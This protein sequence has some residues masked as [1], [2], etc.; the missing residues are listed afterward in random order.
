MAAAVVCNVG[1]KRHYRARPEPFV[2]MNPSSYSFPAAMRLPLLYGVLASSLA[3]HRRRGGPDG[4]SRR[5]F[6][7][8]RAVA[9]VSG[10]HYP[11][12]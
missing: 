1:P 4:T 2:G 8:A 3:A 11:R 10:V 7:A 12:T 5:R 6:D 9:R